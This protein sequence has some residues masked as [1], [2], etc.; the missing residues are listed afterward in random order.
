MLWIFV[1]K[2]ILNNINWVYLNLQFL[3]SMINEIIILISKHES[4]SKIILVKFI[5]RNYNNDRK[6]M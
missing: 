6:S 1:L 4:P 5:N 3:V 2:A